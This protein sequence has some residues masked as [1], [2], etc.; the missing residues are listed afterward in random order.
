[1]CLL[2]LS[3][4][5]PHHHSLPTSTSS[6]LSSSFSSYANQ[7]DLFLIFSD[8]QSSTPLSSL[9]GHQFALQILLLRLQR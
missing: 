1:L 8:L 6:S 7:A 9:F 3:I 2:L 4:L 5:Q